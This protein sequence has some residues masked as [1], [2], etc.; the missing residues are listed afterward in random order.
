MRACGRF[1]FCSKMFDNI[2]VLVRLEFLIFLAEPLGVRAGITHSP[3]VLW[4]T[5]AIAEVHRK[6]VIGLI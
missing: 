6:I 3:A 1:A 4:L 2:G 5:I